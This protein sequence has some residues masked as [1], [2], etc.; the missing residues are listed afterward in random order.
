MFQC[1]H[2]LCPIQAYLTTDLEVL[3]ENYHEYVKVSLSKL[4]LLSF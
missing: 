3:E 2:V 1:L 4:L